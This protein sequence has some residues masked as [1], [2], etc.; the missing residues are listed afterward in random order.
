MYL[1]FDQ[2]LV[3]RF[4]EVLKAPAPPGRQKEQVV[5]DFLENN[6]ELVPLHNLLNHGLHFDFIISKFALSSA[7]T[8]DYAYLTKSSARWIVTFVEL[9]VPE[10]N[11]FNSTFDKVVSSSKFNGALDQ[12]RSWEHYVASNK[13]DVLRRLHPIMAPAVMRRHPVE[14]NYVLIMGRSDNKNASS[15][16]MEYLQRLREK[17]RIEVMSYDTLINW[18]RNGPREKKIILRSKG[19]RFA[20]KSMQMHPDQALGWLGPDS[21]EISNEYVS[22]LREAGYDIDEWLS[23]KLLRYNGQWIAERLFGG[24]AAASLPKTPN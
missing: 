17:E 21:L 20:F 18:Y 2:T 6:S 8:T 19:D 13:D 16:R 14:F 7:L 4:E 24:D 5:Q 1:D 12:V 9:E 23:G 11:F 15:E 3:D 10:K 22:E